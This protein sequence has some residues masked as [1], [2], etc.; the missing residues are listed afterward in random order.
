MASSKYFI[1]HRLTPIS[2]LWPG[3][4]TGGGT[5]AEPFIDYD[6]D[7]HTSPIHTASGASSCWRSVISTAAACWMGS[8]RSRSTAGRASLVHGGGLC[9]QRSFR[10]PAASPFCGITRSASDWLQNPTSAYNPA[11]FAYVAA[12]QNYLSSHGYLDKAYHYIANEPQD[13]ADYDA[14]AWYSRYCTSAA[15]N[16]KLMV[17]EEPKP[18]IYDQPGAHI[19]IWLP[20]L[21]NYNPT[22]SHARERDYGEDDVDLLPPRHA[23]ALLQPDHAGSSR[24]RGQVHRLVL[25]EVS[26]ARHRLL[27][28]QRLE[29]E[30]L[31]GPND[32]RAQRRHLH[33]LP[34]FRKQHA[35]PLRLQR[36]PLRAVDPLGDDARQPGRLRIPLRLARWAAAGGRDQRRRSAGRQDHHRADE[37]HPPQRIYVQPAP[38]HRP[39]ER[40][41]DRH[42][43]RHHPPPTHPRAEGPPGN[44]YINFQDPPGNPPPIRWSSTATPT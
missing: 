34:A 3:G 25:V 2:P 30:S 17:S 28:A 20:V 21:N 42:H 35:H 5:F 24:H 12:M 6:C 1:D 7:T 4:L 41:R 36:P 27:L 9:A 37:L 10:R 44:Y 33:A 31:D 32:R 39:E 15:P 16:L 14:V 23:P 8:S 40:R 11:W 19:D 29:P 43:P 38:P 18:E 22:V 26:R 13:Q